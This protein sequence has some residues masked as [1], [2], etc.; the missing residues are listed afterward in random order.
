MKKIFVIVIMILSSLSW[1]LTF[2]NGKLIE[3]ADQIT[4][5]QKEENYKK[6]HQSEYQKLSFN[7]KLDYL[8]ITLSGNY[9]D[10]TLKNKIGKYVLPSSNW[11]RKYINGDVSVFYKNG[12]RY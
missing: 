4:K 8:K 11:F 10:K 2:K 5:T 12:S 6:L 1:G 7:E 9:I 3:D